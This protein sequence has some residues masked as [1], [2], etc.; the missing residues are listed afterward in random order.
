MKKS[1][2]ASTATGLDGA[3]TYRGKR[4]ARRDRMELWKRNR[5]S[6]NVYLNGCKIFGEVHH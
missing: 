6:A 2:S 3:R 1:W 5:D 4:E